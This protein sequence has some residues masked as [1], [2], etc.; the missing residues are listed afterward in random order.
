MSVH[1]P[2]A[3]KKQT[4]LQVRSVATGDERHCSN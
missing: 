1:D 3:V 4:Q 2:I